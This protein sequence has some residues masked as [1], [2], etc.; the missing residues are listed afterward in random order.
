[1]Y[2]EHRDSFMGDSRLYT[3]SVALSFIGKIIP[4]TLASSKEK[5]ITN[6]DVKN[7]INQKASFIQ[8]CLE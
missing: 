7:N 1:M 8:K 3:S 5:F 6:L 2:L 4:Y